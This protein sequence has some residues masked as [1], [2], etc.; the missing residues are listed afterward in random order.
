MR[1]PDGPRSRAVLIG[2]CRYTSPEL[3][4]LPAVRNN[5]RDLKQVLS[6]P[7]G[8]GIRRGDCVDV[9]DATDLRTVWSCLQ[10]AADEAE[11]LL[12]VYYAGHGVLDRNGHLY[13]SLP[14]TTRKSEHF[15]ALDIYKFREVII[16]SSAA[17]RVL[18]LDC[19]FSGRAH[20]A[21][22]ATDPAA[23]ATG[24]VEIAGAYT[25]T[26]TSANVPAHAPIGEEYTAFT[27]ALL[28]TLKEGIPNGPEL[29][30]LDEIYRNMLRELRAQNAP[31]PERRGVNNAGDLALGIN[32]AFGQSALHPSAPGPA[33]R[34]PTD[35]TPTPLKVPVFQ[36]LNQRT[37]IVLAAVA[38]LALVAVAVV[39]V[40]N[41]SSSGGGIAPPA[42]STPST[43]PG[44]FGMAGFVGM[45]LDKAYVL[46]SDGNLWL[47]N[48]PWGNPPSS[49][50]QPAGSGVMAFSPINQGGNQGGAKQVLVLRPDRTLWLN[51]VGQGA[52]GPQVDANVAAFD[53]NV[54]PGV[55]R[56]Y[57]LDTDGNLWLEQGPWGTVP[58]T[59]QHVDG[60]V[61]AFQT[62]S[63]NQI[64]VLGTKGNLYLENGPWGTVPP[65][66]RTEIGGGAIAAFQALGS[67]PGD[68][69]F[70]LGNGTLWLNTVNGGQRGQQVGGAL[71]AAFAVVPGTTNQVYSLAQDGSLWLNTVG[72]DP[73]WAPGIDGNVVAFD[74]YDSDHVYVLSRDG[75]LWLEQ[76]PWGNVPPPSHQLVDRN[77]MQPLHGS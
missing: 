38:A 50:Q 30:T 72:K 34:Q 23:L 66:G 60:D 59:R 26:S 47:A 28:K 75:N 13:L 8:A 39:I 6:Q 57:V 74:A 2:T 67:N 11:D 63:A 22:G 24:Q 20:E 17:N 42:S 1:T 53:G 70:V 19:C 31:L 58:P 36:R 25:L 61:K 48:A 68:N 64:Y 4:D 49:R 16:E 55:E 54:T 45:G 14:D 76:G 33:G 32:H 77:V 15:T 69:V 71:I 3:P 9:L 7:D 5:I 37:K 65:T 12:L 21:M 18:V 52:A 40:V 44:F 62:I 56:A 46:G 43:R 29:L 10:R 27:G 35:T 51:T 73:H 41:R